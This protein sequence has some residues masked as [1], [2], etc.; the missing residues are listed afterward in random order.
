MNERQFGQVIRYQAELY[1]DPKTEGAEKR[2]ADILEQKQLPH[3]LIGK[4]NFLF[5]TGENFNSASA[6]VMEPDKNRRL[7]RAEGP[8]KR[9]GAPT[10]G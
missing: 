6:V 3:E 1:F 7:L 10:D 9:R 2:L 8:R 4:T 5:R